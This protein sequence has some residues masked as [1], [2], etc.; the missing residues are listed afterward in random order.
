[1]WFLGA[2]DSG[3]VLLLRPECAPRGYSQRRWTELHIRE[4]VDKG[5]GLCL[6]RGPSVNRPA[7]SGLKLLWA[8]NIYSIE[9]RE[10]E[11]RGKGR[12]YEISIPMCVGSCAWSLPRAGGGGAEPDRP[13]CRDKSSE[14]WRSITRRNALSP[15]CAGSNPGG[16]PQSD[17]ACR[18]VGSCATDRH[19]VERSQ[20]YR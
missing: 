5:E 6:D 1:M 17:S 12:Q 18:D 13:A 19:A 10:R 16:A 3:H 11:P 2:T 14:V 9:L 15:G 7:K 8:G 4:R 20:Q